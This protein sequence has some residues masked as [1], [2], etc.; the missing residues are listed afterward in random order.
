LATAE[1]SAKEG[2]AVV[3]NSYGKESILILSLS[4]AVKKIHH[5]LCQRS[6]DAT[7][8]EELKQNNENR[9]INPISS[10]CTHHSVQ[11]PPV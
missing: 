10:V 3:K 9:I 7:K 6:S 5:P 8:E 2:V 1:A 11:L 4:T